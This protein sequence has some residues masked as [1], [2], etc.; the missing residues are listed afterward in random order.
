M[1]IRKEV[2]DLPRIKKARLSAPEKQV[3]AD[4]VEEAA[5]RLTGIFSGRYP[6][7]KG[8]IP[9]LL[10]ASVTRDLII[11]MR[12]AGMK[13]G[14]WI[15]EGSVDKKVSPLVDVMQLIVEEAN[16]I[17]RL[18]NKLNSNSKLKPEPEVSAPSAGYW[19]RIIERA[20]KMEVVPEED[21]NT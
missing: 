9:K 5:E 19:Q 21:Q 6:K 4:A 20:L 12:E 7:K 11:S 17:I 3:L 1:S 2:L 14:W 8:P 15:D 10:L 13:A 18:R 16:R